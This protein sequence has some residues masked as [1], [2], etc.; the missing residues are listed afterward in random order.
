M[1]SNPIFGKLSK[2]RWCIILQTLKINNEGLSEKA[3]TILFNLHAIS[4]HLLGF[5]DIYNMNTPIWFLSVDCEHYEQGPHPGMIHKKGKSHNIH[6]VALKLTQ[7]PSYENV[8]AMSTERFLG[9]QHERQKT[10]AKKMLYGPSKSQISIF[11]QFKRR[12]NFTV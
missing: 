5:N 10:S 7:T 9:R 4:K 12:P 1:T 2:R 11:I 3:A 8:P 6:Y